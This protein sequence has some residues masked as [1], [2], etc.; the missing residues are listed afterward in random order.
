MSTYHHQPV[1]LREVLEFLQVERGGI[2]VDCTTGEGGHS[3]GILK[4]LPPDGVLICIDRDEEM[5][6]VAKERLGGDARVKFL[7]GNFSQI[8]SLLGGLGVEEVDGVLFD[9]GVSYAQINLPQ[10]GF[11]FRQDGPLD[12]RMDKS[13]SL[14]AHMLVNRLSEKELEELF[15]KY[16]EEK[17][18]RRIA[19]A[20]VKRRREREITSTLELAGIIRQVVKGRSHIHP[21]T[22]VFMALRIAVNKELE[23]LESALPQAIALLKKEGRIVVLSYH[24]LED[25]ITKRSFRL[26]KDVLNI[27]TPKPLRPSKEEVAVNPKARSARLR[28]GERRDC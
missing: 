19:S 5:L 11:S 20:I 15:R 21:A 7:R 25:R 22:R 2:F 16:G 17:F 18:A 9:L 26:H 14:T 23:E 24:S 12:M 3:E 8:T 27:L 6:K 1:M 28:A 10:R 4:K 13:Q